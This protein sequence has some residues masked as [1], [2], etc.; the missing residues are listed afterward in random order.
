DN[1]LRQFRQVEGLFGGD[2]VLDAGQLLGLQRAAAG[3]DEDLLRRDGLVL[4]D[5]LDRMRVLEDGAAVDQ[6]DAG[7]AEVG[8]VDARQAGDLDILGL[9]EGRPVELRPLEGPAVA[10][11]DLQGVADLGGH[12]HELLRH[13]AADDAGAADAEPLGDGHALA[14]EGGQSGRAD[15]AGAGADDE[16]VVVV[17]GHS[18]GSGP[19]GRAGWVWRRGRTT[20]GDAAPT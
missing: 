17:V 8:R 19:P 6:V 7:L 12:D 2:V 14:A 18:G 16:E 20:A 4:A 13:A 10:L 9:E 11:G 1:A 15:A 5:D 3:G